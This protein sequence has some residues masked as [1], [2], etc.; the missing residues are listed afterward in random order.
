M[1][2]K[3]MCQHYEWD[4]WWYKNEIH[5]KDSLSKPR[6]LWR[7]GVDE[8]ARMFGI[9][10]CWPVTRDREG[11]KGFREESKTQRRVVEPVKAM[12][13]HS[14]TATGVGSPLS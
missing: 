11:W 4:G 9:K 5:I 2:V 1:S 8:D 10:N 12:S 6:V 3:E 7:D 14:L 13:G